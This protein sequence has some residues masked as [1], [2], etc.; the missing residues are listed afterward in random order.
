MPT[1]LALGPKIG[2]FLASLVLGGAVAY[3]GSGAIAPKAPVSTAGERPAFVGTDTPADDGGPGQRTGAR[4][5]RVRSLVAASGPEAPPVVVPGL[6]AGDMGLAA[7]ALLDP[8]PASWLNPSGFPRITP[9]TQFDGGPFQGANCTLA[10]GAML[11]RLGFGIVTTGSILRTLQNDQVGG[12]GLDDLATALWRGYGVTIKYGLLQPEELHNLLSTGY[13]AVIQGDYAQIPEQLKLQRGFSGGHAIYLDGYYDKGP[14]PAYYVIDP[15]GRPNRYEG[16]WWPASIVDAFGTAL[17]GGTHI[18]AAWVFPPG[19]V[20]P[21]VI[22]PPL[23]L[24]P[25]GGDEPAPGESP[26]PSAQPAPSASGEQGGTPVAPE[27]GDVAPSKPVDQPGIN[28]TA[29]SGG[30]RPDPVARVLRARP[31]TSGL[32]GGHP[33]HLRD[34]PEPDRY[35]GRTEPR[36]QVRRL[37]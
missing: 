25:S 29:T 26:G 18:R 14:T 19:G 6:S 1:L 2:V 4:P 17:G 7:G 9:V 3:A 27:P 8:P 13:G 12:T 24:P 22:G 15:I 35:P 34:T 28:G 11:A 31:A 37:R 21:E 23:P 36:A 10:S 20:P 5:C 16:E 33:R 30:L 32:S